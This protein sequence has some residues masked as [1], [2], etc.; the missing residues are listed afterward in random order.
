LWLYSSN[1]GKT[2]SAYNGSCLQY[3]M[4]GSISATVNATARR[5]R[6]SSYYIIF[7]KSIF[8]PFATEHAKNTKERKIED[9]YFNC[10]CTVLLFLT[11]HTFK[12]SSVILCKEQSFTAQGFPAMF[13]NIEFHTRVTESLDLLM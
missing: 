13:M 9:S 1:Q 12:L 10:A 8:Q 7:C 2:V 4:I 11:S 5:T 3:L 6:G